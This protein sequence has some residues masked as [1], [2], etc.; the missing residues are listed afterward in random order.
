MN[1]RIAKRGKRGS[2][3]LHQGLTTV[4]CVVDSGLQWHLAVV[5]LHVLC[6]AAARCFAHVA[7][8]LGGREKWQSR[9]VPAHLPPELGHSGPL[10][11]NIAH[12]W[13]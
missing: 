9:E 8:Q 3:G 7:L 6:C 5:V 12:S 1:V 10:P 2:C 13:L 11:E 4:D